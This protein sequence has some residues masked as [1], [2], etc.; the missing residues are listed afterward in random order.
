MFLD[1][2]KV[3]LQNV[4]YKPIATADI[5]PTIIKSLI[6]FNAIVFLLLLLIL[7]VTTVFEV[8]LSELSMLF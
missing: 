6:N 2:S 5:T 1:V 4:K 7:I 3:L 8:L